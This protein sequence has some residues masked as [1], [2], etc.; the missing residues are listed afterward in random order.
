Q[1]H[2]DTEFPHI[3]RSWV[4]TDPQ[5]TTTATLENRIMN[6]LYWEHNRPGDRAKREPLGLEPVA[7]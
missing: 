6:S 5:G 4:E 2:F 1:I 7:D 3:I